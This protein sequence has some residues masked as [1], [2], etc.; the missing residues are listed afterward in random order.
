MPAAPTLP[1]I[2]PYCFPPFNASVPNGYPLFMWIVAA[3]IIIP[4][5]I[6]PIIIGINPDFFVALTAS[7]LRTNFTPMIN[8]VNITLPPLE[9]GSPTAM[10]TK[11][12]LRFFI[13]SAFAVIAMTLF[14]LHGLGIAGAMF[15]SG[16]DWTNGL[17]TLPWVEWA[18]VSG[19]LTTGAVCASVGLA[20]HWKRAKKAWKRA[21][22][23]KDRASDED[24]AEWGIEANQEESFELDRLP[25]RR[26]PH[27]LGDLAV[28]KE[29]T[30]SSLS[31]FHHGRYSDNGEGSSR[32]GS[33]TE[34][35]SVRDRRSSKGSDEPEKH[36]L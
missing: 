22:K 10:R 12:C 17:W 1:L 25:C 36:W 11:A 13:G 31:R 35:T 16:D 27:V 9:P 30:R 32:M 5:S 15:C 2:L 21:E 34:H 7:H 14:G 20:K 18:L 8:G 4:I 3:V 6:V 19:T 26:V 33:G 23:G 24:E 29:E 28:I